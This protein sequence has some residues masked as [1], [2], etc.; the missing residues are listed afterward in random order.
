M[1]LLLLCFKNRKDEGLPK[2][3]YIAVS[4]ML[5]FSAFSISQSLISGIYKTLG[6]QSLG[7][8]CI[9]SIA[10]TNTI[11]SIFASHFKKRLPTNIGLLVGSSFYLFFILS[12]ALTTYCFRYQKAGEGLCQEWFI[13]SYAII[14]CI[15]LGFGASFI[16]P[17]QFNYVD[18]CTDQSNRGTYHGLFWSVMQFSMLIGS[19]LAAFVLGKADEFTFFMLLSGVAF[20]AVIM[21]GFLPPVEM[22]EVKISQET[23]MD[24]IRI[25]VKG[26]QTTRYYPIIASAF[27]NGF[28][29]SL[30]VVYFSMIIRETVSSESANIANQ[31]VAFAFMILGVGQMLSGFSVG[32]LLDK[33]AGLRFDKIIFTNILLITCLCLVAKMIQSYGL[34]LLTAF[35]WGLNDTGLKTFNNTIVSSKYNG[36]LE[37]FG[38]LRVSQCLGFLIGSFSS[39]A[40]IDI[41][42]GF[43]LV[44]MLIIQAG[45]CRVYFKAYNAMQK[46]K[47]EQDDLGIELIN[48]NSSSA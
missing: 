4:F 28:T 25:C 21:F 33:F 34:L 41:L 40:F 20:C 18:S 19:S 15:C 29:V 14:I 23:F 48:K 39:L 16:W 1:K 35:I 3:I 45:C 32:R 44:Y 9:F 36:S 47:T 24:S 46:Q 42:Q 7:Q 22:K 38:M 5:L 31:R 37:A 6:Y 12:G 10:L 11:G 27:L 43:Y 17:C 8:V 30:L 2:I 13:F 26:F